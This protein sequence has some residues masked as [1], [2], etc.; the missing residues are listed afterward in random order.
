MFLIKCYG[1]YFFFPRVV[2]SIISVANC[3]IFILSGCCSFLQDMGPA[4]VWGWQQEM[5]THM[6]MATQNEFGIFSA[7][8]HQL[9]RSI[10][11]KS[12]RQIPVLIPLG[13]VY[14]LKQL[15]QSMSHFVSW[16]RGVNICNITFRNILFAWTHLCHRYGEAWLGGDFGTTSSQ[17]AILPCTLMWIWGMSFFPCRLSSLL[18]IFSPSSLFLVPYFGSQIRPDHLARMESQSW[19]WARFYLKFGLEI[20]P[21]HFKAGTTDS[22]CNPFSSP[23]NLKY[24]CGQKS[25]AGQGSLREAALKDGLQME[26]QE[27]QLNLKGREV[28]AG[29]LWGWNGE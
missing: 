10:C 21:C 8:E 20:W 11:R 25:W 23:V 16:I 7:P 24:L 13:S 14:P 4:L 17:R 15:M 6:P 2:K 28:L 26:S 18:S 1:D 5:A 29:N 22:F 3:G 19:H 9:W 27:L 12:Q